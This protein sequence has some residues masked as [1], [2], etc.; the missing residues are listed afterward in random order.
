M[1]PNYVKKI[2]VLILFSLIFLTFGTINVDE[3]QSVVVTNIINKKQS[4]IAPGLHF[5]WPFIDRVDYIF[6]NKREALFTINTQFKDNVNV[7]LST[8]LQWQVIN[9]LIY[10][11]QAANFHKLL[12]ERV[13]NIVHSRI[14]TT[15]LSTFNQLNDLITDPLVESDLGIK[16]IRVSLSQLKIMSI[17][18]PALPIPINKPYVLDNLPISLESAYYQAQILKTNTEIEQAKM[19]QSISNQEPRFYKYFRKLQM[20]KTNAKSK[21]DLPPLDELYK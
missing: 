8:L 15:D 20:Y 19:Y 7:E 21:N 18:V 2:V 17:P 10:L 12:G 16:I 9:P 11:A 3:R 6:I 13:T 4:I 14:A 1:A 5:V